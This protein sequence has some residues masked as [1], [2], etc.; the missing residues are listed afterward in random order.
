VN[1]SGISW[2]SLHLAAE[3]NHASTSL[4]SFLQAGC[5]SCRPTNSVKALKLSTHTSGLIAFSLFST[6]LRVWLGWMFLIWHFESNGTWNLELVHSVS[7][8]FCYLFSVLI[9]ICVCV[10]KIACCVDMH[11][12]YRAACRATF[13]DVADPYTLV[14]T[15][16]RCPAEASARIAQRC[17]W[18]ESDADDSYISR[19]P[20]CS[21]PAHFSW[22]WSQTDCLI[23]GFS[24][25]GNSLWG[26]YSGIKVTQWHI[27][28]ARIL[29]F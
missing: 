11:G 5:P 8:L 22:G 7:G 12:C 24:T 27:E 26:V 16:Q 19:P 14:A 29:M 25:A 3:D 28:V 18:P 21:S 1:G 13:A 6:R 2:A 20:L 9:F 23:Q 15:R 10:C 4:L 17:V